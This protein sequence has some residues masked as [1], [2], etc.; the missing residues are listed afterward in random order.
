MEYYGE[1]GKSL[2]IYA[3]AILLQNS[4]HHPVMAQADIL[5]TREKLLLESQ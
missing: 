4:G 5:E 3:M 1:E 2:T